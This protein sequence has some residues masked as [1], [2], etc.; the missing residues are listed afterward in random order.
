MNPV[1]MLGDVDI[2]GMNGEDEMLHL[3]SLGISIDSFASLFSGKLLPATIM[4]KMHALHIIRDEA[5]RFNFNIA[6]SRQAE[7][8]AVDR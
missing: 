5:G 2:K 4:L 6:E 7:E 8:E 3:K 1:L